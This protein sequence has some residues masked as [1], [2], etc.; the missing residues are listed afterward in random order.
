[1]R[2]FIPMFFL[3]LLLTVTLNANTVEGKTGVIRGSEIFSIW[4][5]STITYMDYNTTKRIFIAVVTGENNTTG[6]FKIVF[7]AST[8]PLYIV[9][10][11]ITF[12]MKNG[13]QTINN[14]T[15]IMANITWHFNNTYSCSAINVTLIYKHS[16]HVI[17]VN[18][19]EL[20]E[21]FR[22]MSKG[23]RLTCLEAFLVAFAVSVVLPLL[24]IYVL[25]KHKRRVKK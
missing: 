23:Y 18:L 7:N 16:M 19:K 15:L 14:V 17:K 3:L 10:D 6:V 9:F 21:K 22:S 20:T 8:P 1:M 4:S 11:N 2:R 24:I 5:N 25:G 12:D 13:S